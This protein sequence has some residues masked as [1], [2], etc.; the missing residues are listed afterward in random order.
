MYPDTGSVLISCLSY[1]NGLIV[2]E[3]KRGGLKLI[4]GHYGG[5]KP[6]LKEPTIS[7]P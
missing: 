1:S 4:E 7:A 5:K 6:V 2:V 3:E